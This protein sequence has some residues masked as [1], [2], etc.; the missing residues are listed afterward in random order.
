MYLQASVALVLGR[1]HRA[2]EVGNPQAR[3]R[4]RARGRWHWHSRQVV[5][6]QRRRPPACI[7]TSLVSQDD[8]CS[9]PWHQI[10]KWRVLCMRAIIGGTC[11]GPCQY[12]KQSC[13]TC[14]G[15]VRHASHSRHGIFETHGMLMMFL[16]GNTLAPQTPHLV[17]WSC[18]ARIAAAAARCRPQSSGDAAA[19]QL[20]NLNPSGR[21]SLQARHIGLNHSGSF[22]QAHGACRRSA[23]R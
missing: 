11:L 6:P 17:R 15:L 2:R 13:S 1:D 4:V 21:L 5:H 8:A 23:T 3:Q 14:A 10:G 16:T 9:L 19:E 18:S 20:I 7:G 22:M 12:K